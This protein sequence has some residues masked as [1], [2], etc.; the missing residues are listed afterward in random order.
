[1]KR[2]LICCVILTSCKSTYERSKCINSY[3]DKYNNK[4]C[5]FEIRVYDKKTKQ[6]LYTKIDTTI[7]NK[8]PETEIDFWNSVLYR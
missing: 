5:V 4:T 1:M 3:L 6:L 7:Y 2:F 8:F